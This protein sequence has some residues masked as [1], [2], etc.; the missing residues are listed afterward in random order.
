M[1]CCQALLVAKV[2][3]AMAKRWQVNAQY[4]MAVVGLAVVEGAEKTLLV[5]AGPTK[6]AAAG[7]LAGRR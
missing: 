5:A 3:L 4:V 7:A 1:Q 2:A 6:G